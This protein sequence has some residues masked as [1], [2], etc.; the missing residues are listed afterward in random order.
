MK[1]KL[2][3]KKMTAAVIGAYT[4]SC[5]LFTKS[6]FIKAN[7]CRQKTITEK[8]IPT[9]KP[10]PLIKASK[11]CMRHFKDC[12]YECYEWLTAS[13]EH[14]LFC[15]PCLLFNMSKGTWNDRPMDFI[16]KW[17]ALL[18]NKYCIMHIVIRIVSCTGVRGALIILWCGVLMS[19]VCTV[20]LLWA[21]HHFR[22]TWMCTGTRILADYIY[23]PCRDIYSVSNP[24]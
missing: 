8:E 22:L 1:V 9:P 14:K 7:F 21:R 20:L 2:K 12:N 24:P 23:W 18:F 5:F 11:V 6:D 13:T 15:W 17:Q 16:Y 4:R 10:N 3:E 19:S